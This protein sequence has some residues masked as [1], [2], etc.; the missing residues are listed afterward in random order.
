MKSARS[1]TPMVTG[2][3]TDSPPVAAGRTAAKPLTDATL[4]NLKAGQSRTDGALPTGNGRL[5]ITCTKVRGALRKTWTFRFRSK[6]RQGEVRLGDW[7]ALSLEAARGLAREQIENVRNGID[8]KLALLEARQDTAQAQREKARL[9]TFASLLDSYVA[10]LRAKN[11]VS[12]RDAEM[13]FERHVTGPWP[14]LA[15]SPANAITPEDCRD[16]LARM[17]EK[18]IGRQTNVTRSYYMQRSSVA[19]HPILILGEQLLKARS[20]ASARTRWRWC[21]SCLT[22]TEREIAR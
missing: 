7:P 3:V 19:P 14:A 4:R 22:S 15:Q 16:I 5:V 13:I 20:T 12:A 8:P 21:R 11:S 10:S 1:Q 9:G 18:G 6:E 2:M 17:V